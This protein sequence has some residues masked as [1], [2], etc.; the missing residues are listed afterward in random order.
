MTEAAPT[1]FIAPK[2]EEGHCSAWGL[3]S[4]SFAGSA[5]LPNPPNPRNPPL[6]GLGA[7]ASGFEAGA[8]AKGEGAFGTRAGGL[9][10]VTLANSSCLLSS[11][12]TGGLASG[13][14][15]IGAEL[16]AEPN[17]FEEGLPKPIDIGVGDTTGLAGAGVGGEGG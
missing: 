10:G 7:G 6:A 16:N 14:L 13:E 5:G 1:P 2:N 4:L 15:R 8:G 11:R 9:T 3:F 12:V 17:G